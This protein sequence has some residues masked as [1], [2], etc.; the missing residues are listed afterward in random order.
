MNKK[1]DLKSN[2]LKVCSRRTLQH[3]QYAPIRRRNQYSD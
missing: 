2:L 3:A 1:I